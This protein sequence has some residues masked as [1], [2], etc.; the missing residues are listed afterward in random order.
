M[1]VGHPGVHGVNVQRHVTLGLGHVSETVQ[2][3]NQNMADKTVM[4]RTRMKKHV[5][6]R[7]V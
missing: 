2:T 5:T 7:H 6:C 4:E 3:L 1:E